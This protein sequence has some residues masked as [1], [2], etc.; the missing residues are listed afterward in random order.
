MNFPL[1]PSRSGQLS[2]ANA[3][4]IKHD[5]LPVVIVVVDPSVCVLHLM[6]SLLGMT[7]GPRSLYGGLFSVF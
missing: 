4:E 1:S 5:H 3:N 2:G 6:N 7:V